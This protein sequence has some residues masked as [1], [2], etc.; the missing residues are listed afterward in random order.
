M[1]IPR[2]IAFALFCLVALPVIAQTYPDRP[3]KIL[4]GF[5]PGGGGDTL[6]RAFAADLNKSL[7]WSVVV[8]NRPGANSMIAAGV[9]AK[10]PPDGYTLGVSSPPDITNA[11]IYGNVAPYKIS[12]FVPVAPMATLPLV[13]V[14]TP[15]FPAN[16]IKEFIALAKE[17]PGAINY[18]TAGVGAPNHLFMELFAY[19]T[20]I[21]LTQIPY[22]GGSQSA[23]AVLAGE[24]QAAWV[25]G[26]QAMPQIR[27]GKFKPLAI[28]SRHRHPSLPDVPTMIE[29]GVPGFAVDTWFGI[30]AP[31]GTPPEIVKLLNAEITRIAKSKEMLERIEKSG[32]IPLYATPAEFAEMVNNEAKLWQDLFENVDLKTLRPS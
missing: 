25:S 26:P 24:V 31:A 3:I 23:A 32:S 20:G 11:L 21:K 12:D 22:K 13:L 14:V 6:A 30:H 9:L 16:N 1:K 29:S 5:A 7:G 19:K 10:S 8:E 2:L 27:A 17:K 28:S 4:V 15:S 18:G